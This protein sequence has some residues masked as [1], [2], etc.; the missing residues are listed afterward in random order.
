[1]QVADW[2]LHL[3][4]LKTGCSEV[5]NSMNDAIT[6]GKDA[7]QFATFDL[8]VLMKRVDNDRESALE[9]MG[10][11]TD[12]VETRIDRIRNALMMNDFSTIASEAHTVKGSAATIGAIALGKTAEILERDAE[13][14]RGNS[15]TQMC[16]LLEMQ[17]RQLLL[18]FSETK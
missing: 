4:E 6:K 5:N 11:F 15:V 16:Q 12:D 13:T 3:R 2:Y 14:K 18:V 1:L 8:D 17:F 7:S 9:I 10:V